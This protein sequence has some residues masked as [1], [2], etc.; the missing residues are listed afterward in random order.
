MSVCSFLQTFSSAG[1]S[2]ELRRAF[3]FKRA[4]WAMSNE[5]GTRKT[6]R[7]EGHEAGSYGS[8]S[9]R[10]TAMQGRGCTV[11]NCRAGGKTH[12]CPWK[13]AI[14]ENCRLCGRDGV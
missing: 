2:D 6:P 14:H 10:R 5:R 8:L 11:Q 9:R 13:M 1:Q 7:P 12:R 3:V 4:S